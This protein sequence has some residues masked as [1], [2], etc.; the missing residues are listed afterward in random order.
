[1]RDRDFADY[2]MDTSPNL[3]DSSYQSS[4]SKEFPA[5]TKHIFV[6]IKQKETIICWFFFLSINQW[7]LQ[8]VFV[9][10]SRNQNDNV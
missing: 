7:K 4:S 1:M 5:K 9:S 10:I 8:N 6:N 2:K 3:S